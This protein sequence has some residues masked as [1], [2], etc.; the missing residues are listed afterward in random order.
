MSVMEEVLARIRE[1]WV[2]RENLNELISFE[3]HPRL[4]RQ[5]AK[6]IEKQEWIIKHQINQFFRTVVDSG[7]RDLPEDIVEIARELNIPLQEVTTPELVTNEPQLRR[8]S[9]LDT[10]PRDQEQNE[11]EPLKR[12]DEQ[13]LQETSKPQ[14]RLLSGVIGGC[15]VIIAAIAAVSRVTARTP[16]LTPTNTIFVTPLAMSV[17][18]TVEYTQA[19]H[20]TQTEMATQTP[21]PLPTEVVGSCRPFKI[22]I[23]EVM[24]VP[25]PPYEDLAYEMWNEYV[26]I[27]N[28]GAEE[29]DVGGWW[30]ADRGGHPGR[31]VA[32]D[33]RNEDTPLGAAQT[34]STAIPPGG[35]AVVLPPIYGEGDRPYDELFPFTASILTLDRLELIGDGL[36]G[37]Q[38]K[39]LDVIVL[40]TGSEDKIECV[41]STYGTPEEPL[42]GKFPGS[43]DDDG[44]D[45]LPF[46][47]PID[48]GWGGF[49]RMVPDGADT[50]SNWIRMIWDSKT[51]GW[52]NVKHP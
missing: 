25:Q 42:E 15:V 9:S 22:N 4:K 19:P 34:A 45:D 13:D 21:S 40:Y 24:T 48:G 1:S 12:T 27:F 11:T 51:P 28:Y 18:E 50:L 47:I 6:Q 38:G 31:I 5:Y 37:T 30:I 16:T 33:E 41:V 26:E 23:N 46:A 2:L 29:I 35:Y 52:E 36:I 10:K 39:R 3:Y 14:T 32:W 7:Y 43:I 20:A 17:P 8:L 49:Q 44:A